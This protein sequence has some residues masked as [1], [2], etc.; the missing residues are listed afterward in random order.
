MGH[1]VESFNRT[2]KEYDHEEIAY[3]TAWNTVKEK[4]AKDK[5]TGKWKLKGEVTKGV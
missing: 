3:R 5:Q 4:Y 1:V 2:W